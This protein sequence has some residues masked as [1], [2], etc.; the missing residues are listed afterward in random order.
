[1]QIRRN[2]HVTDGRF[3]NCDCCG[4]KYFPKM[5]ISMYCSQ[6]CKKRQFL[7]NNPEK[8]YVYNHKLAQDVKDARA[9]ER[10][11]KGKLLKVAAA[12]RKRENRE[13]DLAIGR[14]YSRDRLEKL[15][16]QDAKVI[17]CDE[18][19]TKFCPLYGSSNALLC[20]C[21][22]EYRRIASKATSKAMRRA[23]EVA[24]FIE[25]VNPYKVFHAAR[26]MCQICGIDTPRKK[27]GT[28]DDDAPELDHIRPLAKGGEHSYANTQCLCRKCNGSKSDN[29]I[30]AGSNLTAEAQG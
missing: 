29:F 27:R 13:H 23:R 24:S 28:Y 20:T 12:K 30:A 18:C 16:R 9:K 15:H 6:A 19:G 1:M 2:G 7:L 26:W 21:C 22:K 11:E 8:K 14:K 4:K 3:R 5:V 25:E 10:V 17:S